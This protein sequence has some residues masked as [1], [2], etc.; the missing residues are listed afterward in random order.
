VTYWVGLIYSFFQALSEAFELHIICLFPR[1]YHDRGDWRTS[2][3]WTQHRLVVD[4][5][6]YYWTFL[7]FTS[8]RNNSFMTKFAIY[9]PHWSSILSRIQTSHKFPISRTSRNFDPKLSSPSPNLITKLFETPDL[10]STLNRIWNCS[11]AL[12]NIASCLCINDLF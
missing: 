4:W 9:V 3:V 11:W 8:K 5:L 12:I 10:M 1:G 6:A 7:L 2:G